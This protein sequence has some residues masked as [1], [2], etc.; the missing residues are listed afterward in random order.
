LNVYNYVRPLGFNA[1]RVWTIQLRYPGAGPL[2]RQ[3]PSTG[4]ITEREAAEVTLR[5]LYAAIDDLPNVERFAATWPST[6]YDNGGWGGNLGETRVNSWMNY[7]DDGFRDVMGLKVIAGRWFSAEDRAVPWQPIVINQ[8]LA[9]E[10]FGKNDPLNQTVPD[11]RGGAPPM[12]VVGVID[13]YRQG[14]EFAQP[15]NYTFYRLKSDGAASQTLPS[16]LTIRVTPGTTAD[17][18]QQLV[19]R[20]EAVAPSWSFEIQT[21]ESKREDRLHDTLNPLAILGVVALF[22]L[23]MVIL[24]MTGVVWQNVTARIQE[25]GLRRANGAAAADIRRQVLSELVLLATLALAV[26]I[27][28]L[29]QLPIVSAA[30]NSQ[31]FTPPPPLMSFSSV[32]VSVTVIYLLTLLCGWYP[33]RLA[34]RIHPAEALHYE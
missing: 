18:E 27:A 24:G 16:N 19:E 2:D 14:G 11:S 5:Q 33:S 17:F 25:F 31:S 7:A 13:D 4:S 20:L 21:L 12:R 1:D 8:R 34:T 26:G 22:L 3:R 29:V 23:L 28:I 6:A 30:L 9:R 10:L 15:S 32:A